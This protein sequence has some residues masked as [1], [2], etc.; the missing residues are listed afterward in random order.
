MQQPTSNTT[1]FE[2]TVSQSALEAVLQDI[3]NGGADYV[4]QFKNARPEWGWQEG[5]MEDGDAGQQAG[6]GRPCSQ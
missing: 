5:E 3:R 6:K 1:T 2:P 4:Q